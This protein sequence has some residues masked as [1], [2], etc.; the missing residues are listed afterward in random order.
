M[1][2]EERGFPASIWVLFTQRNQS[3]EGT[4]RQLYVLTLLIHT[5][6]L[7]SRYYYHPH[8]TDQETEAQRD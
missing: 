4:E 1:R 2:L 8:L 6:S 7:C 3:P 5:T